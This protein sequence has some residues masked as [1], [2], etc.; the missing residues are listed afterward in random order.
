MSAAELLDQAAKHTFEAHKMLLQDAEQAVN[1]RAAAFEEIKKSTPNEVLKTLDKLKL[2]NEADEHLVNEIAKYVDNLKLSLLTDDVRPAVV[3]N[4]VQ[5]LREGNDQRLADACRRL[6]DHQQP[7]ELCEWLIASYRPYEGRDPNAAA[8]ESIAVYTRDRVDHGGGQRTKQIARSVEER[9][10]EMV[11]AGEAAHPYEVFE[12]TYLLHTMVLMQDQTTI[13]SFNDGF[14]SVGKMLHN[15][16]S[17]E[18]V[19]GPAI[20][21]YAVLGAKSKD[22]ADVRQNI[23]KLCEIFNAA[24]NIK[25]IG[26]RK[27]AAEAIGDL[28]GKANLQ[29]MID[30]ALPELIKIARNKDS[31]Q[32]TVRTAAIK[33]LG[34]IGVLMREQR[35][36]TEAISSVLRELLH[37]PPD[38]QP[39]VELVNAALEA[40]WQVGDTEEADLLFPWSRES[41][42]N[43]QAISAIS[44]VMHRSPDAAKR[45]APALL[46]WLINNNV[47]ETLQ[48]LPDEAVWDTFSVP[49]SV[50]TDPE[51]VKWA[52]VNELDALRNDPRL[53]TR[54]ERWREKLLSTMPGANRPR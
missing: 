47:P 46:K 3:Q 9:L 7:K 48:P 32:P 41:E 18:P 2:N 12:L 39:I 6:L 34:K 5:L 11:R 10:T 1:V 52:I 23:L 35:I 25:C 30:I 20:H 8:E 19:M 49:A 33:S 28:A 24:N 17:W 22:R 45:V 42:V 38:R 43:L 50:L 4:L 29:D 44:I 54:A 36:S 15:W 40:F 26:T 37:W 27:V 51:G 31:K 13:I 21:A 53:R 16:E 14:R